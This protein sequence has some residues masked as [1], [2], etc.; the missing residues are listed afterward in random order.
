MA[1]SVGADHVVRYTEQ[2]FHEEAMRITD[3]RGVDVVYDSVGQSTADASLA[4]LRPRGMMV[5]YGAASG[6]VQ[7]LPVS[8]INAKS[9]FFTRP[10][11]NDH[12]ATREELMWRAGDVLGVGGIGSAVA[13]HPR[14]VPACRRG[15]CAGTIWKIVGRWG[16][17]C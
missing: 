16:R 7:S 6:A 4:S 3:G 17:C 8:V 10:G 14:Y 9:L 15:P 11:L 1:R 12:V 2:D 5:L 13:A